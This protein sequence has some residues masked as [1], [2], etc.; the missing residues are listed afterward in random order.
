MSEVLVR[1]PVSADSEAIARL[2]NHYIRDTI[3]TFEEQELSA[4]DMA[5]RIEQVANAS[6]PWLVAERA[7]SVIGHAYA[8]Q[9][10]G[11]SAYRYS[12]ESTVYLDYRHTGKGT[13]THLYRELL[14]MLRHKPIHA[15]IGCIALPNPASI[16]LH[17]RLGFVKVAHFTEIGYK[18]GQWIDVGYW[19]L[20]P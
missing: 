6:L 5:G 8:A 19:Q 20:A 4:R 9:W 16:A 1:P 14:T 2:Y 15:V 18:F 3:V 17:E 12:V 11:R 7:G 13:G 10:H